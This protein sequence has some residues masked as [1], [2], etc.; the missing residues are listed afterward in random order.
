MT[1]PDYGEVGLLHRKS[2]ALWQ[3]YLERIAAAYF[4]LRS[5]VHEP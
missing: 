1:L 3:K 2:N 5:Q 4:G